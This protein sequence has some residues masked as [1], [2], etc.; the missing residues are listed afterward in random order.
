MTEPL[1]L[2]A[3]LRGLWEEIKLRVRVLIAAGGT[4]FGGD[5][6]P[7]GRLYVTKI[8]ADGRR[9]R[10]G[11]VSTKVVTDSGVAYLVDA[12]QGI[13]EPENLR[14][15][16][17][18]TGTTAESA[19]QTTLVTET[20]SR[21]QGSLAENAANVF[22]TVATINFTS[23]LAITEHGVFSAS[24]GGTMLDRSVFSAVNVVNG[25]AIEF[26]YRLTLPS[27]S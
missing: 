1:T 11:L 10:L 2:R 8:H 12:L 20:G 18:G 27:G 16:G 3:K 7:V 21:V 4:L 6:T 23:S 9:E 17:C 25:D 26:T 5:V 15:H 13:T 22:Q 14:W 19:A 24:S